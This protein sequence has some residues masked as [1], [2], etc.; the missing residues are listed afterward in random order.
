MHLFSNYSP[1]A[2]VGLI[3]PFIFTSI[4]Y[5]DIKYLFLVTTTVEVMDISGMLDPKLFI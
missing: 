5:L 3:L 4:T 2:M 1:A